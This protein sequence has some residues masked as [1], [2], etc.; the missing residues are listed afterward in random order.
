VQTSCLHV[1]LLFLLN[2]TKL[3]KGQYTTVNTILTVDRIVNTEKVGAG[4][5]DWSCGA[6]AWLSLSN[7]EITPGTKGYLLLSIYSCRCKNSL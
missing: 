7:N 6:Q 1:E 3:H 4:M 2:W 5:W